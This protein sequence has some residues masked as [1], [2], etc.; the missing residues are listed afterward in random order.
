MNVIIKAMGRDQKCA[1][2][3]GSLYNNTTAVFTGVTL[4]GGVSE[5]VN[6][7]VRAYHDLAFTIPVP[8]NST[9]VS[10]VV[11]INVCNK[12]NVYSGDV[13]HFLSKQVCVRIVGELND[14]SH[15]IHNISALRNITNAE[16]V[17]C[18]LVHHNAIIKKCCIFWH[19]THLAVN[20]FRGTDSKKCLH[21]TFDN[22][23][24]RLRWVG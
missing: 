8:T 19:G 7:K 14:G 6:D 9:F 12:R 1:T 16:I 10:I 23:N 20:C 15:A 5:G 11:V 13:F 3:F 2:D 24:G 17:T 22:E 4:F 18:F 21:T